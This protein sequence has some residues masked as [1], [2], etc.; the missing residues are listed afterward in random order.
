MSW[1]CNAREWLRGGSPGSW[2]PTGS[3]VEPF[4]VT[5][6]WTQPS[7]SV[8]IRM[9][10][11]GNQCVQVAWLFRN[12]SVPLPCPLNSPG[13]EGFAFYLAHCGYHAHTY[14][15]P[16]N[17]WVLLARKGI[18]IKFCILNTIK[19]RLAI[20]RSVKCFPFLKAKKIFMMWITS[21][22]ICLKNE[23]IVS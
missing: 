16:T 5:A 7:R 18:Q 6:A 20:E 22:F 9:R 11:R 21:E 3:L 12:R 17:T 13:E 8:R 1:K 4:Q 2:Q 15:C 10:D 19:G 14:T 23:V